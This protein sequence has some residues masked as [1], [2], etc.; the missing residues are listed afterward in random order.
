MDRPVYPPGGRAHFRDVLFPPVHGAHTPAAVSGGRNGPSD[1]RIL[2]LLR[3]K[4]ASLLEHPRVS[5]AENRRGGAGRIPQ[6]R[7]F[8]SG[9]AQRIPASSGGKALPEGSATAHGEHGK[10][11]SNQ[12]TCMDDSD[13]D[14][15]LNKWIKMS[16]YWMKRIGG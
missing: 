5:R 2:F 1:S 13:I 15:H 3:Q 8:Q 16:D 7:H 6:A 4:P 12:L 14:R 9:P 11:L 10:A